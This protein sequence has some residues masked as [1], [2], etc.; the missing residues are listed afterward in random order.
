MCV[1]WVSEVNGKYPVS[2]GHHPGGTGGETDASIP[3]AYVHVH[4]TSSLR[5]PSSGPDMERR[6]IEIEGATIIL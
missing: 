6:V 5:I 4:C 1:L 2:I 3:G